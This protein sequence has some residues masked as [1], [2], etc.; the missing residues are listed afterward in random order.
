MSL[1]FAI[2]ADNR[3]FMSTLH[4]IISGVDNA[5]RQIEANGGSIDRVISMIK[6]GVASIGIGWG[7]KELAS[8]VSNTRDQFQK[9]EI[10]FTTFLGSEAESNK[11]MQQMVHT[12]ATTPFDLA[13]VADGA[14]NLLAFGVAAED[15]NKTII[16]LGD[17]AAGLSQPLKDIIYLY[18][19]TIVKPKMD[20]QDL[21]QMMGRGIPIAKELAKQFGVAENKVRDLI[22]SGK[23]TGDAVKKA[24]ES[25][26]AEGSM[27]GGLMEAQSKS[28]GGQIAN[29]EDSIDEMFNEI[30]KSSQGLINITLETTSS[31]VE[32][33]RNVL[34]ILGDITAAYG[35]QKAI[36]ALDS[37]FTKAAVNYGY[38]TEIEQ[39]RALIPVKEE[40]AKSALDQAVASGNLTEAKAAEILAL[41][42]QAEAQLESLAAQEAAAK[43]EEAS[44]LAKAKAAE[45]EVEAIEDE[46]ESL[47]DK[48]TANMAS[49]TAEEAET[50]VTELDT[51]ETMRN[52]AANIANAASE[53]ARAAA[54]N[55][56]TA[57]EARETLATQ[58][59]TAQTSGNTAATGILTIAKEKLA[60]ALG[61]VNAMLKANQF[62]IVTGAVIALGYAIYKLAT[63]QSEEEKMASRVKDATDKVSSSYAE[64]KQKLDFLKEKLESSTKGSEKWKSAKDALISQYGQYDSKLAAEIDKVGTLSSSYDRLTQAIRKSIAAK[65]LKEFH[66]ANDTSGEREKK[67]AEWYEKEFKG[68]L[69]ENTEKVLR[70]IIE[71]FAKNANSADNLYTQVY[72]GLT[73]KYGTDI[74]SKLYNSVENDL[75]KINIK[76]ANEMHKGARQQRQ[77]LSM[78]MEA[79]NI[80]ED[81]ANEVLYGLT[82]SKGESQVKDKSYWADKKKEAQTRLEALDNIAAAGQEGA[83]IKA[84]IEKYDKIIAE[85][86]TSKNKSKKS[87]GSTPE[88]LAA[89]EENAQGK[90]A[91]LLR[92][93]AEERLRIEQ[94]YEYERWQTR[95]N[96][97]EEGEAKI[98]A[99]QKLDNS[100]EQTE[101]ERRKKSDE[102]AELQRQM[103]IFNAR[104][105]ALAAANKKYA[106]RTF[107]D[108]DIDQSEFDKINERYKKLE[109][110]LTSTQKKAENDRLEAAK[111]SMNAYLKEF[112]NYHQKRKAIEEEYEKKIA[113]AP[114]RGQR[115][116][117]MAGKDKALA[118]L[119]F[120]EWQEN[121]G[122]SLAFGD[123][124]R[125]SKE[126]VEKLISDMEK[127]RSKIIATFDPDKIQKFDEALSNLRNADIDLGLR[128]S[129]ENEL[130]D[131]MRERL[132]LQQQ[133]ADASANEEAL[134]EQ[135]REIEQELADLNSLIFSVSISTAAV[136]PNG[137]KSA[138]DQ[139][140]NDKMLA[141]ADALRVKLDFVSRALEK[142]TTNSQQLKSQLKSLGKVKF[143]DIQKFSNN[144]LKAGDN[145]TDLASIFNDD[146]ADAIQSGADKIGVMFD[147]F[148]E[149][150][151]NIELLAQT[152]KDAVKKSVDASETIVEGASEGM[153]ASATATSSSLST[154]EK[155]SAILAIISAAIQLA[156][157]VASLFNKDKKH[158]KNIK[159][160]QDQI[161]ALDRSYDKLG[162]AA[163]GAFST[164][165]SHLID[166]QNTLLQQQ[167]VLIKQ[168]IAEEEAKKKTDSN[169]IKQY[170]EQLDDINDLLD[171]NAAK[172][173]EAILG[174]DLKSAINE[175]SSLYAEAWNDGTDAAQ[176]SMAAV[177]NIISS[178]LSELLKKN[179]QPAA[180]RFY[181]ALAEA[182]KDGVLTDAELD[183]LDILKNQID[184]LA[185]SSEEQWKK[186]QD[187]Y[188]DLDELK[189]ELTDI[190]FDSVRDNFK[191]LLS[192][193]ESTTADFI[194]SFSDMLRDALL[195]GLMREKY[196][197]ML[198]E[199]YDEFAEAMNDRALT[200]SER[201]V[202]R[203][204][205]DDI[206]QQGLA[207]RDFINSIIGG[208]PYSQETSKG[209]WETMGQDQS[210]ELNG[211]FTALT[212]LEAINNTLVGEGNV[213]ASQILDTLR[214][215]TAISMT[216]E[217]DDTTLRD[218]RDMM[219]L[220]TGHLENI[221]KYTKQLITIREGID[222]LN[223]LIN[224]RL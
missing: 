174:E 145:A 26:T 141:Q 59:N 213:I 60:V 74:G 185:A 138:D 190:S 204:K 157:L 130:L 212:E 99:Q 1:D 118:D 140:V 68:K 126:T 107:R 86:S 24:F 112:G 203:Q 109:S 177:K 94:D 172:A 42:E 23:V 32:N 80:D 10:A 114:N 44:A 188:K 166:Q 111:E 122:M 147:A 133:I 208:T 54:V 206:V 47:W 88:Q 103:A 191:S 41:R 196:D 207:D 194:D 135:K 20:T 187:R 158:E 224:Q 161:D 21:M 120:E 8:Q 134:L 115:K 12:A 34:L 100:K 105:D 199:W 9:L 184:S 136:D 200:D 218:I 215:L 144:L 93:Q 137:E 155:A 65:G 72:M 25:M 6:T 123:L 182:M 38:D 165:A 173:K 13:G 171:D 82:P 66:D 67:F 98:L 83:K 28:I 223:D 125:L 193:M 22:S 210:E 11:L 37:A 53:E 205:Y 113:E 7:F 152:G 76:D 150:S 211:R 198:K 162:K 35:S 179:I 49:M 17:I 128:F 168:Q 192:D 186:I 176:K 106:K 96:L 33:W 58:I 110:D 77:S 19:T 148:T 14:K 160:L 156:T 36:L 219:F 15:V 180:T 104:E 56:A 62:A 108:S 18:G 121:G 95:I 64:E 151:S 79:N 81:T 97:M 201:E 78:Y 178:A 85:Y 119:D 4:E 31:I 30:G 159:A 183:N 39:L 57:S 167:R 45:D 221:S 163:E 55:S 43:A 175:F 52:E 84:E 89:K 197:I 214:G 139:I 87:S 90:I 216:T 61:K 40:E 217:G 116:I 131:S 164:D 101:L 63:Y 149:L 189:E 5:T 146:L 127:Y 75:K 50:A 154:L 27:F 142:S 69:G 202:L 117:A 222:K 51:L 153:K 91:D 92:K 70:P 124:S 195:E 220:S 48:I 71:D 29:I 129:G 181:D 73:Q 209:G 2:T 3:N 16:G 102:E 46:I 170:K 132:A 143:A 169:K